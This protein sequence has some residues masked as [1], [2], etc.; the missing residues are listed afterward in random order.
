MPPQSEQRQGGILAL[1]SATVTGWCYVFPGEQPVY[2]VHRIAPAGAD[3]GQV[4][5]AF[6]T[7]L[8]GRIMQFRPR[9]IIFEAPYIPVARKPHPVRAGTAVAR[10]QAGPPPMNME[11]VYRLCGLCFTIE[12]VA[13]EFGIGCRKVETG[14][15]TKGFTGA[16][17]YKGGREAKKA[18]VIAACKLRGW[19]VKDSDSADAI[20]IAVYAEALLAPKAAATRPIGGLF[21]SSNVPA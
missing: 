20:G 10:S 13:A 3:H 12:G 18:A 16:G 2:G 6:R 1:D 14:T 4:A 15:W 7:W 21:G 17:R 9:W 19:D 5:H 11:T 8:G